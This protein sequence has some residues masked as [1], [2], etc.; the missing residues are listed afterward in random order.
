MSAVP[1][2]ETPGWARS[3][4]WEFDRTV[5]LHPCLHPPH[6][7]KLDD[8]KPPDIRLEPREPV[9]VHKWQNH[10]SFRPSEDQKAGQGAGYG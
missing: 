4:A 6:P 10:S 5:V 7:E 2:G 9:S 3:G 1:P 8:D